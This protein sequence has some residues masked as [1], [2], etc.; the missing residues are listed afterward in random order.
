MLGEGEAKTW[1]ICKLAVFPIVYFACN[2]SALSVIELQCWTMHSSWQNHHSKVLKESKCLFT[3]CWGIQQKKTPLLRFIQN[4]GSSKMAWLSKCCF[5]PILYFCLFSYLKDGQN[6][7]F[8]SS[9]LQLNMASI[10]VTLDKIF[11]RFLISTHSWFDQKVELHVCGVY[12]VWFV[13]QNIVVV[14]CCFINIECSWN[15]CARLWIWYCC[16]M[17]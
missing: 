16:F 3:Q 15:L 6:L 12:L 11:I 14:I 1:Q 10:F 5:I 2:I 8:S 7:Q 17:F 13:N 4:Y 9:I